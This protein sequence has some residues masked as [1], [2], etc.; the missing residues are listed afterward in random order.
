MS[1]C[2]NTDS[3]WLKGTTLIRLTG[4][5]FWSTFL[6]FLVELLLSGNNLR[7][8][9]CNQECLSL[10]TKSLKIISLSSLIKLKSSFFL[11]KCNS[12]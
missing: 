7:I 4:D 2:M 10:L 8:G 5:L 3:Y 6:G 9:Y 1:F 11:I 12:K